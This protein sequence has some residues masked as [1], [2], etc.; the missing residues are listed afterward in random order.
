MTQM[1]SSDP[2]S[3][4]ERTFE[5]ANR[6]DLEAFLEYFHPDYQSMAPRAPQPPSMNTMRTAT[7][8]RS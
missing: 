3:V 4:I 6:H 2:I 7:A 1:T 8:R 5:T